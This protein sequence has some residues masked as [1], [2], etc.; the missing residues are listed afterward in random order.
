M[1]IFIDFMSE[2]SFS[3]KNISNSLRTAYTT[4]GKM[5]N[6]YLSDNEL[7]KVKNSLQIG[8]EVKQITEYTGI[9]FDNISK[10]DL[11]SIIQ[12]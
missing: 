1:F 12:C 4:D 8:I 2:T 9:D 11:L 6:L 7:K 3:K 5:Y 10:D